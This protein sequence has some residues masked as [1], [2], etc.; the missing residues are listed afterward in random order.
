MSKV[1]TARGITSSFRNVICVN[2]C[3]LRV[4]LREEKPC[5]HIEKTGSWRADV[6]AYGDTAIVTGIAPF[7]NIVPS[8]ELV[9]A[10]DNQ[11]QKYYEEF[12]SSQ[13]LL[14]AIRI[15]FLIKC[16]ID[17]AKRGSL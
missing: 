7:G 1:V 4:L 8:Y 15:K 13:K 5:G 6:Y 14:Y 9:E 10:I 2:S 11:A 17:E 12:F 3:R 16:F